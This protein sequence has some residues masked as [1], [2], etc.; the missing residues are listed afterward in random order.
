MNTTLPIAK[1]VA[2]VIDRKIE[3]GRYYSIRG[4]ASYLASE[5]DL[6][7]HVKPCTV[8]LY[9]E[10]WPIKN[11]LEKSAMYRELEEIQSFIH[12]VGLSLV[13]V[14]IGGDGRY[15]FTFYAV[16]ES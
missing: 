12:S 7:L 4:V 2:C 11:D 8:L 15:F 10:T 5:V 9:I 13:P 16:V 14:R 6:D 3:L 1:A